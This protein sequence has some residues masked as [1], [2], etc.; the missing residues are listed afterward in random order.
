LT[1]LIREPAAQLLVAA[2]EEDQLIGSVTGGWNGWRGNIYCLVVT[3]EWRRRGIERRLVEA[4]SRELFAE[5]ATR[6]SA[7]VE[8]EHQWPVDFWNSVSALGY[9]RDPQSG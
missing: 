5:G 7:L 2:I 1:K 6:L 9:R 3:P 4:I 8:Y